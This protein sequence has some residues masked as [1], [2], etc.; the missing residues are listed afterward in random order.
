MHPCKSIC[1]SSDRKYMGRRTNTFAK[2]YSPSCL[3]TTWKVVGT[4]GLVMLA[5]KSCCMLMWEISFSQVSTVSWCTTQYSNL[6]SR[7]LPSF[8]LINAQEHVTRVRLQNISRGKKKQV[9]KGAIPVW[10]TSPWV[11][12]KFKALRSSIMAP[13]D[14][15]FVKSIWAEHQ[16][17]ITQAHLR[18]FKTSPN[19]TG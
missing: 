12:R 15:V 18:S 13:P 11:C 2:V 5:S 17:H 4:R 6:L 10:T 7:F 16:L 8:L 3:G 1:L 9:G 14:E 19:W